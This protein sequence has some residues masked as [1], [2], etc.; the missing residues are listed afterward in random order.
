M[1]SASAS[2]NLSK[3][4]SRATRWDTSGRVTSPS[5]FAT[6]PGAQVGWGAWQAPH[7]VDK[8]DYTFQREECK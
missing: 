2:R 5:H 7:P 3:R 6:R 1:P 8:S 4:S